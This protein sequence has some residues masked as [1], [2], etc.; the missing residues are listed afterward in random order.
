MKKTGFFIK[1]IFSVSL[2]KVSA[3]SFNHT[4]CKI[5]LKPVLTQVGPLDEDADAREAPGAPRAQDVLPL[6]L[7]GRSPHVR[8]GQPVRLPL[9][10]GADN[11]LGQFFNQDIYRTDNHRNILRHSLESC[12]SLV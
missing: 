4:V 7:L 2:L 1:I 10:Q 12:P 5:R 3:C 8:R 11:K 9:V 6:E